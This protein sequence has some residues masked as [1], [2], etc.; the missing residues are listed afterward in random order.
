MIDIFDLEND[1]YLVNFQ[2]LDDYMGVLIGGP[3]VI[4]N[5]YLS[6]SRWKPE[7]NPKSEKIESLVAWVRFLELPAPLFDKK[8]LLNLGNAIGDEV[9]EKEV[10]PIMERV[11]ASVGGGKGSREKVQHQQHKQGKQNASRS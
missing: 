9:K 1:F 3:W 6:V 5:A 10:N 4:S 7:F 2:H 8:I 11:D